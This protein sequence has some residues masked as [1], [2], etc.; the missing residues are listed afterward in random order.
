[1]PVLRP[2]PCA[3]AALLALATAP[4]LAH[5]DAAVSLLY[6]SSVVTHPYHWDTQGAQFDIVADPVACAD[7]VVVRLD[8]GS[9]VT[10][11]PATRLDGDGKSPSLYRAYHS[12]SYTPHDL[13]FS[14]RCG[15]GA[16]SHQDDNG[17]SGYFLAASSGGFLQRGSVHNSGFSPTYTT[18]PGTTYTGT[19]VLRN[20]A[21]A[22]QVR[23]VYSTDGWRTVQ[24][25]DGTYAGPTWGYYSATPNPN[26][27]GLEQ[28][29]FTLDLGSATTVEYAVSYTVAGVTYWDNNFTRN[30]RTTVTRLP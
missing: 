24:T 26:R 1:M 5:A 23:I 27:F 9:G 20:L 12:I 30:Y 22:K 2:I 3:A 7:S 16:T 8:D 29:Y 13:S 10:D 28:W 19:V 21:Y 25:A 18:G 15:S 14:I 4:A 17:G 11:L 6:A